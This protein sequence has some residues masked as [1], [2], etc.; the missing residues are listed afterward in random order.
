MAMTASRNVAV[1]SLVWIP[2]VARHV[3]AISPTRSARP[4]RTASL[5]IGVL[6]LFGVAT[7]AHALTRPDYNLQAYPVAELAWMRTHG[8][9][10]NRVAAP[11]FVGNYRTWAEGAHGEVFLD[12]RYD[13]Y[14]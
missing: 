1:A 7:A 9:A 3:P 14:P 13:M 2:I 6:L 5:A 8:L 4:P 12:D 11:D 10:S